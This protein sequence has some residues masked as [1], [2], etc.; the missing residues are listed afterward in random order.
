MKRRLAWYKNMMLAGN[1]AA[2]LCGI[3]L[4]SYFLTRPFSGFSPVAWDLRQQLG[5]I[6]DP[7]ALTAMVFLTFYYERPIRRFVNLQREGQSISGDL[8]LKARQRVLNEPFFLMAL[9]F[10]FWLLAGGFYAT[11]FLHLGLG[12]EAVRSGILRSLFTGLVTIILAFFVLQFLKQRW[13][14]P[15]FFPKGGLYRTPKTLRIRISTRLVAM[16]CAC[17]ILPLLAILYI[18]HLSPFA[19][20][21]KSRTFEALSSAVTVDILIFITLGIGLTILV[22]RNLSRPLHNMIDVLRAVQHGELEKR[23]QVTTNDELGYCGDVIN[24]MTQGLEELDFIKDTFG[25]YVSQ[26]VRDE[27]LSGDVPLD[28]ETKEVT[29]LFADLR[30]ITLLVETLPPRELVRIINFYFTEMEKIIH[31]HHGL[32]LQYI[33]DEIEAVFGAPL[34][35]EDH[36]AMAVQAALDMQ[37]RL[38]GVNETLKQSGHQPLLHGIGIHSGRALAANIGSPNRLSYALVGE[39]VNL[40]SR[41]QELSKKYDNRIVISQSTRDKLNGEVRLK[42]LPQEKVR[43]IEHSVEIYTPV[44]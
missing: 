23:V 32:V 7:I 28:G 29:I 8:A 43:G 39:T 41:L 42:P 10:C 17:N 35:R 4:V 31:A 22:S 14:A 5:W 33:G 9:N 40:A 27:I 13:M 37:Q 15:Y 19:A 44:A 6:F 1:L 21:A 38:Q 25:K 20:S 24:E 26:E 36:A 3:A 11:A 18:F 30:K 16:L 2:N 12:M 34:V